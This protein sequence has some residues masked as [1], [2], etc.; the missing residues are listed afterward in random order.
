MFR[1]G[2]G[3][4]YSSGQRSPLV[5]SFDNKKLL[6]TLFTLKNSVSHW[7]LV[8]NCDSRWPSE[9]IHHHKDAHS[10]PFIILIWQI[11]VVASFIIISG[12]CHRLFLSFYSLRPTPQVSNYAGLHVHRTVLLQSGSVV[13]QKR[14]E[15]SSGCRLLLFICRC[16]LSLLGVTQDVVM[17]GL[18]IPELHLTAILLFTFNITFG[19]ASTYVPLPSNLK[20]S[21]MS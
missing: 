1:H 12:K 4:R 15:K 20:C 3:P 6:K 21:H 18:W 5:Q 13:H 19:C 10:Y 2:C 8:D 11:T 7:V 14:V 17:M 9:F 16:P